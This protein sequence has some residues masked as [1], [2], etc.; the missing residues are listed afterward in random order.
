M[1]GWTSGDGPIDG[2]KRAAAPA[3]AGPATEGGPA[4]VAKRDFRRLAV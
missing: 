1:D 4:N 2:R 3:A